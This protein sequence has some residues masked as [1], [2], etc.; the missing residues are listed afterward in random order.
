MS[1]LLFDKNETQFLTRGLGTLKDALVCKVTELL[2]GSYEL[3]LEYP[4][5]FPKYDLLIE[6]RIVYASTPRGNQPFRIY[7][8]VENDELK[9]KSVYASHIFYD[10]QDN[11]VEDT[12]I[13][14]KTG[15]GA[16]EQVL[17]HTQYPHNFTSLCDISTVNNSRLVRKDPVEILLNTDEDNCILNRWGG[18]IERDHFQLK[19]HIRYGKDRGVAI[20]YG[21]NLKG[22]T[23][24]TDLSG[25]V[26]RIMPQGF[27]GLLIPEKYVDSEH[28]SSYK[29]PK[30]RKYEFSDVIAQ[31]E[32][33]SNEE[34]V[35]LEEAYELLRE[36]ANKLFNENK[37]DIPSTTLK[38]SFLELRKT[39]EYK[40]LAIL[41][42]IYPFDTVT[43]KHSK[44]NLDIKVNMNYYE[45]DSIKDEYITI[46]FGNS[47]TNFAN[48]IN[49]LDNLTNN[50]NE[51]EVSILDKAKDNATALINTG[52]GG[53]VLKTR[54]ELLIMDTD[55]IDTAQKIWRWN[56]NGLGY[57]NT[58]YNGT[59]NLAMTK[60]GAIVADFITTGNLDAALIN[61]GILTAVTIKNVD[62]SF[63]IDLS[64]YSGC[65]FYNSSKL[66]MAIAGNKMKFYNWGKDGDY[67]GSIGSINIVDSNY[68]SGNPN[69]P[70]IGVWND[71]DS[72]ISF[73]YETLNGTNGTYISL[74]K[75]N[76]SG[77]GNPPISFN[78][79]CSVKE[80]EVHGSEYHH[81]YPIY[82]NVE[83]SAFIRSTTINN[84]EVGAQIGNSLYVDNNAYVNGGYLVNH[85]D[86]AEYFEWLDGNLNNEDRTGYLVELIGD[87]IQMANGTNILGAV[88]ANPC[89]IGD[90]G[91]EYHDKY[92]TDNLGRYYYQDV[93]PTF[94]EEGYQIGEWHKSKT[95][96]VLHPAYNSTLEY[97]PRSQRKEWSTIGLLG[98][99]R[100]I[101]DG[102]CNIGEY[103]EARDGIAIPSK[104]KT[105]L[106]VMRRIDTNVI[107]VLVR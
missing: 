42:R 19:L 76:I 52:L 69:K 54:D 26:T 87:K 97:I 101:D 105:R 95:E 7:R 37:I 93:A 13:V 89:L 9:V 90:A 72:L 66:A 4:L 32:D 8:I 21:K 11:F 73:S 40:D 84:S 79:K 85:A 25:V 14:N 24:D 43:I 48:T 58:G 106:Q 82:L 29:N 103:I 75:Y 31:S 17:S 41:E 96:K 78:E 35:P 36:R 102:S 18:E 27:N 23:V 51:I 5:G 57:S 99:L 60:D 88:S 33:V 71:L 80:I 28:I 22:L 20:K 62:G 1:N 38:V 46:E 45:W 68:P 107:E 49:R 15:A 100:V 104:A 34:A 83:N 94:D 64:G 50:I 98:K 12:N 55:N 10:L 91:F 92:L 65:K 53:Y 56:I 2:N 6:E 39:S 70:C 30:I 63:Q 77:N 61:T 59:F 16:L 67:I 81:N 3:Y 47:S 44:F 86:Y 74:D